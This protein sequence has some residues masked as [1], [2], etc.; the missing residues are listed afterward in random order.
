M[1]CDSVTLPL[2]TQG[3]EPAQR[4]LCFASPPCFLF[5]LVSELAVLV[6]SRSNVEPPPTIVSDLNMACPAYVDVRYPPLKTLTAVFSAWRVC[7][8]WVACWGCWPAGGLFWLEAILFKMLQR[9][10]G[11]YFLRRE[12]GW[13]RLRRN[14]YVDWLKCECQLS[15]W[16]KCND[17]RLV[18]R[19]IGLQI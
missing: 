12:N 17:I 6:M 5:S 19:R 10:C 13:V 2:C 4:V 8:P 7:C 3:T 14:I 18:A 1:F 15:M 9:R 11:Q 16:L